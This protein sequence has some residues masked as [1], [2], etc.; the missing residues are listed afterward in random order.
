MT[1]TKRKPHLAGGRIIGAAEIVMLLLL[2]MSAF[3]IFYYTDLSD[4]LNNSIMLGDS[5]LEGKLSHFYTYAAQNAAPETMYSANYDVL[6][7]IVFLIWN[8]PTFILHRMT[9]WNYMES[10]IA[11]IWCKAII[12]VTLAAA[13]FFL[14]KIVAL[15]EENRR[16]LNTV[17]IVFLASCGVVFSALVACQYDSI[18]IALML[19][20]VYFYLRRN[21]KLFYLFF[22]LAVPLKMFALFIYIPLIL[23]R[24]KR[25]WAIAVK[26]IPAFAVNFVLSLPFRAD[27]WYQIFLGAQSRDVIQLLLDSSITLHSMTI[28]PFIAVFLAICIVCYARKATEDDGIENRYY[29]PLFVCAVVMS[30]FVLLVDIRSY[31]YILVIPFLL[32]VAFFK[33]R[34]LTLNMLIFE[35]GTFCGTLYYMMHHW[36]LSY[37]HLADSL[38][39][40]DRLVMPTGYVYTY[41]GVRG[42]FAAYSLDRFEPFLFS[43]FF[44]AIVMLL[45]L[46]R[47]KNGDVKPQPEAV[48]PAKWYGLLQIALTFVLVAVTVYASTAMSPEAVTFGE[49][50]GYSVNVLPDRVISR[51]VELA[52]DREATELS[53]DVKNSA[54]NRAFRSTLTVRIK[55]ADTGE[56]LC[57]NMIGTSEIPNGE[58]SFSVR[59]PKISLQKG[60]RYAVEFAGTT[61]ERYNPKLRIAA[62]GNRIPVFQIR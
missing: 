43:L 46:N 42:L 53:F 37:E 25:I 4:T 24:E 61:D 14:R 33:S 38:L 48:A 28:C 41:E 18:S 50:T 23:L 27:R 9:E 13:A 34:D 16:T 51:T 21:D 52:E 26:L 19:A 12:L 62:D 44:A 39:L 49:A 22:A 2:V 57:E 20:G 35:L 6:M 30:S 11:F 60:R 36:V 15:W 29:R 55:N 54:A 1:R 10:G 59:L 31:W 3:L 47:P 40:N 32:A 45:V 5:I 8:L 58:K 56:V 7:Y 17:V